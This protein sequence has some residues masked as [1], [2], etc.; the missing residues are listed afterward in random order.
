[1]STTYNLEWVNHSIVYQNRMP[2]MGN[3]ERNHSHQWRK[4]N[5]PNTPHQWHLHVSTQIG[6]VD[7]VNHLH[8]V[9][10]KRVALTLLTWIRDHCVM[11]F[12]RYYRLI[13]CA[14]RLIHGPNG[15]F[16][17]HTCFRWDSSVMGHKTFNA[18]SFDLQSKCST[19]RFLF[20]C[21]RWNSQMY[22]FQW[23]RQIIMAFIL[24]Y[25]NVY[26]SAWV[27]ACLAFSTNS[28]TYAHNSQQNL[29]I[30]FRTLS[31]YN[32]VVFILWLFIDLSFS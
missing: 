3:V 4:W 9:Y 24:W 18:M 30:A 8:L 13:H 21:G 19:L 16:W 12:W 22:K 23:V 26:R 11:Q 32:G 20:C 1:M 2:S 29:V 14:L 10:R 17:N 15:I 28:T 5:Q 31:I 27:Y 7:F 6:F 25:L